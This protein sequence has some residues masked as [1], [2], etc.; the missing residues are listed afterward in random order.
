M[1]ESKHHD[2][3]AQRHAAME[4]AEADVIRAE[5]RFGETDAEEDW[6]QVLK[7]RE[8]FEKQ[9]LRHGQA[10]DRMEGCE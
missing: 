3:L 5:N 2:E 10:Q 9:Q 4:A 8:Q 7:C 6:Q 1:S